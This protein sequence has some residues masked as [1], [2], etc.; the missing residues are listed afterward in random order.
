MN[1]ARKLLV[2]GL[3]F[4]AFSG[5]G[6]LV[7][8]VTIATQQELQQATVLPETRDLGEFAMT[9]HDGRPF[10]RDALRG[11]WS[12]VFFGFTNCPDICPAT[13]QQLAIA[14]QR[15]ADDGAGFPRIILV[16]V[17]PE[18]DTPERLAQYV[19]QFGAGIVG[20]TGDVAEI[21]KLTRPLGIYFA[22]SGDPEGDY[23]VDHS[24]VVLLLNENGQWHS[25][26]SAP[27]SVDA[28]VHD[29]PMLAGS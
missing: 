13:L 17:D 27:H 14:R 26:F 24:A 3:L 18:R 15:L 28:F 1:P 5:V 19:G 12:L 16:S 20:V 4:A 9:D 11:S 6:V 21:T 23:S 8:Y 7:Y 22:K 10:T 25:L 29:I 2:L